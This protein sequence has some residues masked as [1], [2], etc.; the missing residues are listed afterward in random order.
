MRLYLQIEIDLEKGVRTKGLGS[1]P[2]P[3]TDRN[4]KEENGRFPIGTVRSWAIGDVVKKDD[5]TWLPIEISDNYYYISEDIGKLANSIFYQKDP[6]DGKLVVEYLLKQHLSKEEIRR[7]NFMVFSRGNFIRYSIN[8]GLQ[9]HYVAYKYLEENEEV[10]ISS[11]RLNEM[12]RQFEFMNEQMRTKGGL[13]EEDKKMFDGMME[14]LDEI[15]KEYVPLQLTLNKI[16]DIKKLSLKWRNNLIILTAFAIKTED[17]LKKYKDNFRKQIIKDEGER[18]ILGAGLSIDSPTDEFYPKLLNY[19]IKLEELEI[20]KID[21]EVEEAYTKT[22]AKLEPIDKEEQ[23]SEYNKDIQEFINASF[24]FRFDRVLGLALK[25]DKLWDEFNTPAL[26][27]FERMALLLPKGHII[28]NSK[29]EVLENHSYIG[30]RGH[31]DGYAYYSEKDRKVS[32]SDA[33]LNQA[34]FS[35]NLKNPDEFNSVIS[36]E[37]GHSVAV[38]LRE[39]NNIEFKKFV[40]LCGWDYRQ[41]RTENF[42]NTAGSKPIKRLGSKNDIPLLT[43]YSSQSPNECFAEYYSFYYLN[44][45]KIDKWLE[46]GNKEELYKEAKG[47]FSK[48]EKEIWIERVMKNLKITALIPPDELKKEWIKQKG[49]DKT[50]TIEIKAMKEVKGE[51]F[52]DE[53]IELPISISYNDIGKIKLYKKHSFTKEVAEQRFKQIENGFF[54]YRNKQIPT[55]LIEKNF[56]P[57][58]QMKESIFENQKIIKALFDLGIDIIC[59]K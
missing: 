24:G 35:G 16:R 8:T 11:E 42:F 4:L 6:I 3:S 5:T 37:V 20:Q 54:V 15:P 19:C 23:K 9:Q 46:T 52:E 40:Y 29:L 32:L 26:M 58:K 57:L 48:E 28:N 22:L 10:L 44:K 38:K 13:S 45:E 33:L 17:V 39:L 47:R 14:Q 41:S 59:V 55:S 27:N 7:G 31:T 50:G 34:E 36:H 56:L 25:G 2:N 1:I 51:L 21:K 43:K 30:A 49:K 53:A 12:K 18:L